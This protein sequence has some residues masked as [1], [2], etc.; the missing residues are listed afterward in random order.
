METIEQALAELAVGRPVVVV[1]G[2]DREDE[3]D[4]IVAAEA[5]NQSTMAFLVRHTSGFVCVALPHQ[6]CDELDLPPLH[7]VGQDSFGTAYRVTVDAADGVGT[8]ISARDRA[9]TARLLA[10]G[11]A[12]PGDFVRPGHVVPLAARPGGV[13]ERAGHTEAAVDLTRLAGLT[14]VGV[15]CEIVST[16]WPDRMARRPELVDFAAEHGLAMISI[17]ELIAYR[18][19]TE[20]QVER[21]VVT[22]LPARVGDWR[23]FGYRSL[24]D[25]G[26]HLALVT[27]DPAGAQVPVHV[28]VECVLGDV[29]GSRHCS[30]AARL[31]AAMTEL[32]KARRGVLI[33]LRPPARSVHVA[34]LH[35]KAP[36]RDLCEPPGGSSMVA[37]ATAV[38]NDLGVRSIRHLHNPVALRAALD[39]VIP[40][41]CTGATD[42]VA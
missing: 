2:E 8:G 14:P 40:S 28:H 18:R 34:Q 6:R 13:L 35:D 39:R 24:L 38:L 37:I 5:V 10:S 19:R 3:G 1:D 22:G 12:H 36:C 29:F 32:A 41:T 9:R 42:E 16:R 4:L 15:L 23:A 21:V 20:D 30:C 31:D 7:P 17:E 11:S 33:Y 27:G 26:E 25:Q